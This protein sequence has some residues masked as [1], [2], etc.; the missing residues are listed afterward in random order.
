MNIILR[1]DVFE[2]AGAH[3]RVLH[4]GGPHDR[5]YAIPLDGKNP[6]PKYWSRKLFESADFQ[7]LLRGI[8]PPQSNR[9]FTPSP[10]DNAVAEERWRRIKDLVEGDPIMILERRHRMQTLRDQAERTGATDRTL[11]A[12]LRRWWQGGQRHDALLGNYYGSGRVRDDADVLRMEKETP[13][14]TTQVVFAPCAQRARGRRSQF[15]TH[16]PMPIPAS[17]RE[18]I[19]Q[20]GQ[21]YYL[22]D[23]TKSVRDTA[24]HVLSELFSLRDE[25]GKPLRSPDGKHAVLKPLGQRPSFEQIRYMLRKTISESHAFCKRVSSTDFANNHAASHGSV[26]DDTVGA[27]D[28]YEIDATLVDLFIVAA[29]DR[30]TIIGK[31]TL[32]LVIDRATRLIVG[33][34]ISLENPSWNEAKQAVLSIAGDWATLCQRL[35]V[36]YDSNDWPAGGVLPSRFVG[37]RGEMI[38]YTSNALCD[39]L[40]IPITNPPSKLSQRKC[41]VESGFHT[42]QVPLKDSA[43]GYE[44]PRNAR[45]RRGKKYDKDAC[46][47]LDELA[48]IY[49]RIVITHNNRVMDG[50]PLS[51]EAVL[52][53][54]KA[55]PID[56]WRH[57]ITRHMGAPA[58]HDFSYLR[59]QLMPRGTGEVHVDGVHF[60]GCVYRFQDRR[61]ADWQSRASLKESFKVQVVFSPSL[62]DEVLIVDPYDGR[63]QYAGELTSDSKAFRGYTFA[64]VAAVNKMK[65]ALRYAGNNSNETLRI[66]LKQDIGSVAKPAHAAMKSETR[67]M[68]HRSRYRGADEIRDAEARSRRSQAHGRDGVEGQVIA[69]PESVSADAATLGSNVVNLRTPAVPISQPDRQGIATPPP[70]RRVNVEPD[71]LGDILDL[72]NQIQP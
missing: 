58:R 17:L 27:G 55:T 48:V 1:N 50:Y 49:L 23:E 64:E 63:K 56:L 70:D 18:V 71:V 24:D 35:G 30:A 10:A 51:P 4:V 62:V 68:Q 15:G 53:G 14:G 2:L 13:Y 3:H 12:D 34:Y 22:K 37:D 21:K 9:P 61:C 11:L 26:L 40:R 28:V 41:I 25:D 60:G 52:K 43:P 46:L 54:W 36:T 67:G 16:E 69:A 6:L 39:G 20:V 32:Y 31:A 45:K 66:A 8:A 44:P 65:A 29:A 72:L 59:Q 33:F 38:T 57:S 7:K 47:T 19:L 5:V 42:T